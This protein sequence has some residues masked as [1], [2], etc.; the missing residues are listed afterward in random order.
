MLDD[1]E[2]YVPN[3]HNVPN[4]L[5]YC[6]IFSNWI[7]GSTPV[8][9]NFGSSKSVL[10][11]LTKTITF[12]VLFIL[13]LGT[14]NKPI[15]SLFYKEEKVMEKVELQDYLLAHLTQLLTQR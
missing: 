5:Q 14:L 3:E 12:I 13:F 6:L 4:H 9:P 11:A 1:L 10:R 15:R 7:V 8:F 2:H